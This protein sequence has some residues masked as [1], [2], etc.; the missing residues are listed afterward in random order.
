[1]NLRS[2][3]QDILCEVSSGIISFQLELH[4]LITWAENIDIS[5]L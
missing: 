5:E 3:L 1:M 2:L 4:L